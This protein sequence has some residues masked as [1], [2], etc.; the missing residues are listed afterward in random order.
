MKILGLSS[1][2]RKTPKKP[3]LIGFRALNPRLNS[4]ISYN[5][6]TISV[7]FEGVT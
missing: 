1:R 5:L 4:Q 6:E 3:V 2:L 7:S